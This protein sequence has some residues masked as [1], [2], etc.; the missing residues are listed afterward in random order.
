MAALMARLGDPDPIPNLGD[1]V[2]TYMATSPE[3]GLA[4]R[5]DIVRAEWSAMRAALTAPAAQCASRWMD[6]EDVLAEGPSV[7][8]SRLEH[9]VWGVLMRIE[10]WHASQLGAG[11]WVRVTV[12]PEAP[13]WVHDAFHGRFCALPPRADWATLQAALCCWLRDLSDD[14]GARQ[15]ARE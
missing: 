14:L 1:W 6:V 8:V 11:H 10:L 13:R 2:A 3:A 12:A 15:S 5:R 4:L 9:P 7:D